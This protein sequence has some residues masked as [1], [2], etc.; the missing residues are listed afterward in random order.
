VSASGPTLRGRRAFIA[1][2]AAAVAARPVAARAQGASAA[3]P[4][5]ATV[6]VAGTEGGE[7]ARWARDLGT[8]LEHALPSGT[9]LHAASAGGEDGVTGANQFA[10]RASPDGSTALLVPGAAA[11]SWLAGDPRAHFD[12][13]RWVPVMAGVG[14]VLVVG[15]AGG[16]VL[17]PG[18][19]ARVAVAMPTGPEIAGLLAV[20]L[21]G[22]RAEPVTVPPGPTAARDAFLH[23]SVDAVVLSGARVPEQMATFAQAGGAALFTL[24]SPDDPD[25]AGG[26]D[27]LAGVP[28]WADLSAR[29]HAVAPASLVG[30]CRAAAAA[31][32]MSYGLVLPALTPAA[33]VAMWRNAGARAATTPSVR[34]AAEERDL[35]AIAGA[36]AAARTTAIAADAGTLLAYRRWLAMRLNWRPG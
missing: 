32:G 15:R 11:L 12:A 36:A 5:R 24:A 27:P 20:E 19:A 31:A 22:G 16:R 25:A 17:G 30:A 23:G 33:L 34:A 28:R 4:D 35:R 6:L 1:A 29:M 8:A 2:L 18:H 14:P 7:L 26:A 9:Q 3:F 10:T 21:L 13:A